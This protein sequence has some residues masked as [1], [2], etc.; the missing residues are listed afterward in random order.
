MTGDDRGLGQ[1]AA[2]RFIVTG[3]VQG[4][5]FRASTREQ[6]RALGL[7][8]VARNRDDGSVEVIAVGDATAIDALADWL[9]RGPPLARVERL[10]RMAA[11]DERQDGF[12]TG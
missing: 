2:A 6:A 5:F 12:V 8:G 10:Q 7:S 3:K 4:V 1:R 9:R 11:R